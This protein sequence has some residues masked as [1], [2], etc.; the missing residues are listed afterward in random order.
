MG[1]LS[2]SRSSRCHQGFAQCGEERELILTSS[3]QWS[4][5]TSGDHNIIVD[6][7]IMISSPLM[8]ECCLSQVYV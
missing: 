1:H 3:Q 6:Y 8:N 2:L 4:C 5:Q 7:I